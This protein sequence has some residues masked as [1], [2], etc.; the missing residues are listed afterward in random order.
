MVTQSDTTLATMHTDAL[1]SVVRT[2]YSYSGAN[3]RYT[4]YGSQIKPVPGFIPP[5][6]GWVGSLGYKETNLNHAE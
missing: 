2:Q 3:F 4:P 6:F 1:G 5:Y